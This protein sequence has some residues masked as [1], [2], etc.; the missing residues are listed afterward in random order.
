M[1]DPIPHLFGPEGQAALAAVV[2]LRPL[3]AFDF[4][5]TLAP[6]VA[7][8]EDV[9]VPADVVSGLTA[10]AARLPLAIVTGRAIS[11]VRDRLGFV[12]TYLVG[13]H[14]AEDDSDPVG[15]ARRVAALAGMRARLHA[16]RDGLAAAGI[17]VE[18]KRA[19]IALHYRQ[20]PD[21]ARARALID[22]LLV[23]ERR[24]QV[25]GGKM[26]VNL[27]A[28]GAP[29]KAD[30]VRALVARCGAGA[31]LFAGDDLNDE[32][33]FAAAPGHWLALRVGR[34][35]PHSAA[36]FALDGPQQMAELLQ[37]LQALL[38]APAQA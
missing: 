24:L 4:D 21:P 17:G 26:V 32:P 10:L 38:A 11:D 15:T 2:H 23:S 5:G 13:S 25:F 19:S 27:M 12:P 36:R 37:R 7:R 33:V 20:A 1:A 35:A 28:A 34:D 16:R 8:P 31:A 30:A 3:L 14:G 18:D 6:I 29:D 22:E 9:A